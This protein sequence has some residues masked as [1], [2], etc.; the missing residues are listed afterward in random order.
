MLYDLTLLLPCAVCLFGAAILL[1][2]RKTNTRAQDILMLCLILSSI[3]FLC[4]ANYIAGVTDYATYMT[5]DIV[6]S[7]VT[8]LVIP[9]MY[10]YFRALTDEGAFTWKDSIWFLPAFFI[11]IGTCTL[12]LAMD[13]AD[14][15]GYIKTVLVDNAPNTEYTGNI[16]RL[17]YIISVQFFNIT[18]LVQIIGAGSGAII[19]FRRYH[20]RIKEFHSDSD[21]RSMQTDNKILLWLLLTITLALGI[22]IPGRGFWRMHP[23]AASFYYICWAA[24]Y[25]GMF[26][27]GSLK[28]Y[29][30]DDLADDLERADLEALQNHYDDGPEN[31]VTAPTGKYAR[32]LSKFDSLIR[33]ECVFLQSSLRADEVAGMMHTNR[34]YLSRMIREEFQCSFSDYINRKRIE[35]AQELMKAAPKMRMSDLAEQSGFVNASAFSRTFKQYTGTP[36][37]DWLKT[38]SEQ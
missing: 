21:N 15:V 4:S 16:F 35:Y 5:L 19:G 32:Y 26:Y 22:I 7:F 1:C 31:N 30:V 20:N 12:Y 18:V 11:G 23:T 13:E 34:T 29:T 28:K 27:Y 3:F 33:E 37:K 14:A 25:F 17:H 2:K 24:V 6:D 9:T 8:L 38:V 36:P 10:L